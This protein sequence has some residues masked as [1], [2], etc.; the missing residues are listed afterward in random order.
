MKYMIGFGIVFAFM[1]ISG[2]VAGQ[3]V[4]AYTEPPTKD[5]KQF[6]SGVFLAGFIGIYGGAIYLHK[7]SEIKKV[8]THS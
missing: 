7:T 1:I 2:L 4:L 3:D 5:A 8:H 6:M